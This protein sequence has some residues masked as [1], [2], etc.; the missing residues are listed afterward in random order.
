MFPSYDMNPTAIDHMQRERLARDIEFVDGPIKR[1]VD[2]A[3]LAR[4]AGAGGAVV[5][6]LIVAAALA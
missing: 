3:R 4:R 1:P 2:F 6:L 5:A